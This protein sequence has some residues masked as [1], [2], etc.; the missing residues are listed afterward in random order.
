[1]ENEKIIQFLEKYNYDYSKNND[2]IHVKLDFSLQAR[3]ECKDN[4]IIVKDMLSGYNLLTG[5][6]NSSLKKAFIYNFFV[7]LLVGV[8]YLYLEKKVAGLN[9]TI[10]FLFFLIWI[11]FISIFYLVK[12]E[13]FKNQIVNLTK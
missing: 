10:T 8:L 5:I 6:F 3:I 12:F 2:S 13:S 11:L 4:K 7:T 9:L 1:M